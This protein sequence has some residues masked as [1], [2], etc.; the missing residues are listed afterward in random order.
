MVGIAVFVGNVGYAVGVAVR[1]HGD[2]R[3]GISV[4]RLEIGQLELRSLYSQRYFFG[5]RFVV[6]FVAGIVITEPVRARIYEFALRALYGEPIFL[7]GV[8][9]LQLQLRADVLHEIVFAVDEGHVYVGVSLGRIVVDHAHIVRLD[10]LGIR[11]DY[12][13]LG[14]E[15]DRIVVGI[16]ARLVSYLDLVGAELRGNA[17][18]RQTCLVV[19]INYRDA[20]GF[21]NVEHHLIVV[22]EHVFDRL[23]VIVLIFLSGVVEI[24]SRSDHFVNEAVVVEYLV[25]GRIRRFDKDVID[26]HVLYDVVAVRTVVAVILAQIDFHGRLYPVAVDVYVEG[27]HNVLSAVVKYLRGDVF[28]YQIFTVD[29]IQFGRDVDA[30]FLDNEPERSRE[31]EV[32]V[33]VFEQIAG[34]AAVKRDIL[35]PVGIVILSFGYDLH[36]VYRN[37]VGAACVERAVFGSDVGVTEIHRIAET[38]RIGG[39]LGKRIVVVAPVCDNDLIENFVIPLSELRIVRHEPFDAD[40]VVAVFYLSIDGLLSGEIVRRAEQYLELITRAEVVADFEVPGQGRGAD[41]FELRIDAHCAVTVALYGGPGVGRAH[42]AFDRR[43]V[44]VDAYVESVG[45]RDRIGRIEHVASVVLFRKYLGLSARGNYIG[46]SFS[47]NG[48]R[49]I[50]HIDSDRYQIDV[51]VGII[52][53]YGNIVAHSE[54][55]IKTHHLRLVKPLVGYQSDEHRRAVGVACVYRIAAGTIAAGNIAA[56]RYPCVLVSRRYLG[57]RRIYIRLVDEEILHFRSGAADGSVDHHSERLVV[58]AVSDDTVIGR[59]HGIERKL[60]GV[61]VD[62]A[63]HVLAVVRVAESIGQIGAERV[64]RRY[65]SDRRGV[66]VA[67]IDVLSVSAAVV[68]LR[69]RRQ[70]AYTRSGIRLQFYADTDAVDGTYAGTPL[71]GRRND[72]EQRF[73]CPAAVLDILGHVGKG[74]IAVFDPEVIVGDIVRS[75]S[76]VTR[77]SVVTHTRQYRSLVVYPRG[78]RRSG[79][80]YRHFGLVGLGR[81]D[82]EG[83][84]SPAAG[85]GRFRI[86]ESERL[87][88]CRQIV[89]LH[90]VAQIRIA[91]VNRAGRHGLSVVGVSGRVERAVE[92]SS[93]GPGAALRLRHLDVDRRRKHGKCERTALRRSRNDPVRIVEIRVDRFSLL[94]SRREYVSAGIGRF[95][96]IH[97]GAA[98][99]RGPGITSFGHRYVFFRRSQSQRR[100]TRRRS[101]IHLGSVVPAADLIRNAVFRHGTE[102]DFVRRLVAAGTDRIDESAQPVLVIAYLGAYFAGRNADVA[103][104][105]H[106]MSGK[107]GRYRVVDRTCGDVLD[108]GNRSIVIGRGVISADRLYPVSS[109]GNAYLDSVFGIFA[110]GVNLDPILNVAGVGYTGLGIALGLPIGREQAVVIVRERDGRH[111]A[112]FCGVDQSAGFVAV[113]DRPTFGPSLRVVAVVVVYLVAFPRNE[114]ALYLRA[115]ISYLCA[116]RLYHVTFFA[117]AVVDPELT[118]RDTARESVVSFAHTGIFGSVNRSMDVAGTCEIAVLQHTAASYEEADH[119]SRDRNAVTPCGICAALFPTVRG[120]AYRCAAR[121]IDVCIGYRSVD[122]DTRESTYDSGVFDRTGVSVGVQPASRGRSV[123]VALLLSADE[124]AVHVQTDVGDVAEVGCRNYTER[125]HVSGAGS[126]YERVVRTGYARAVLTGHRHVGAVI[127]REIGYRSSVRADEQTDGVDT[128]DA[129]AVR[130]AAR[131]EIFLYAVV[132]R[133]DERITVYR[134]YARGLRNGKGDR[135]PVA[136]EYPAERAYAQIALAADRESYIGGQHAYRIFSVITGGTRMQEPFQLFHGTY[137]GDRRVGHTP[138][139]AHCLLIGRIDLVGRTYIDAARYRSVRGPYRRPR[140][141]RRDRR[142]RGGREYYTAYTSNDERRGY[143]PCRYLLAITLFHNLPPYAVTPESAGPAYPK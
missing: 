132:V 18:D 68:D 15:V 22:V 23:A 53:L 121:E 2:D 98:R 86:V 55:R 96:P 107:V 52:I 4:S 116:G 115:E 27:A 127:D 42:I 126:G 122:V 69:L 33:V 61:H 119:T 76:F 37:V 91:V 9:V 136:V 140:V 97:V 10:Y 128:V 74:G 31:V 85:R 89:G 65:V 106:E 90:V 104:A 139:V 110:G 99:R 108:R 105:P 100:R 11:L 48:D 26:V 75:R 138:F 87:S 114:N 88:A 39:H 59:S 134:T 93:R 125:R 30:V 130:V 117:A 5:I 71:I 92:R 112:V 95:A 77:I 43:G 35:P 57:R 131:L 80:T 129:H 81:P 143:Q 24:D 141:A 20:V 14:A 63:E 45:F 56:Q 41:F 64:R 137:R 44:P 12:R 28:A 82:C 54:F 19:I 38:C 47:V 73:R 101:V 58:R 46:K 103:E 25:V 49:G 66:S 51:E 111:R 13:H 62:G 120:G 124:V 94:R 7:F 67:E 32:V 60:Y 16:F 3:I 21:G 133:I 83:R 70:I 29:R 109:V 17:F 40:I 78:K 79:R 8:V 72:D 142:G 123:D 102:H 1:I 118:S 36:A 34:A 50:G 84:I 113:N 6:V 135:M